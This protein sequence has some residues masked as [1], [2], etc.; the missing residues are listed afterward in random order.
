MK[1]IDQEEKRK[2]ES[3]GLK[4]MEAK[5]L[6]Q[7]INEFFIKDENTPVYESTQDILDVIKLYIRGETPDSIGESV[8]QSDGEPVIKLL[9][10]FGITVKRESGIIEL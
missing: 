5:R 8:F 2:L 7:Q 4:I 10:L 3:I 9:E 6:R 1:F